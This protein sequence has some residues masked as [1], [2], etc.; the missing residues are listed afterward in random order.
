MKKPQDIAAEHRRLAILQCL[1]EDADYRMN[2]ALLQSVLKLV[3]ESAPM[4]VLNADIAWLEQLGL[5]AKELLPACTMVVLRKEG[6]D[7]AEGL[8]V[9]P[10]IARPQPE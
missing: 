5:V 9:I 3:G 4:H 1:K 2:D 6:L 8:T 7:V 10:G